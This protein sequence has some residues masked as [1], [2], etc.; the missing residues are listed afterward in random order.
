MWARDLADRQCSGKSVQV[1][2]R[3]CWPWNMNVV[4]H[5]ASTG[6]ARYSDQELLAAVRGLG[7]SRKVLLGEIGTDLRARPGPEVWSA[8]E[9]A[10]HSR[11]ITALHVFGVQ[12]ALSQEEPSYPPIDGDELIETAAATYEDADPDEVGNELA[13]RAAE[14]ADLA[15]EAGPASWT[16]G[17][18]IGDERTDVRRLIE[19]ALHDSM[20][21]VRDVQRGLLLI[22][23]RHI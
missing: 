10:A 23:K 4:P 18:T 15:A 21:H 3:G 19:H 16:R 6:L 11:D 12:Q 22:R 1:R 14:L 20:H 7:P 13:D 5:V 17:L 8:I 9:Y 2:I